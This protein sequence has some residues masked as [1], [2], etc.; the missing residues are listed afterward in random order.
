MF[1]E[2]LGRGIWK[3]NLAV[4]STWLEKKE[5]NNILVI[6]GK[7][8]SL[9]I[10]RWSRN[11]H[12]YH[13]TNCLYVKER[14]EKRKLEFVDRCK[15]SILKGNVTADIF[16]ERV[17]AKAALFVDELGAVESHWNSFKECLIEG[18]VEEAVEVCGE[19]KG[20]RRHKE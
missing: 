5:V 20:I 7:E 16:R 3:G 13:S 9:G 2:G 12:V 15:I 19:T 4:T 17:Q 10:L 18:A 6:K 14:L 1:M 8:N 11:K